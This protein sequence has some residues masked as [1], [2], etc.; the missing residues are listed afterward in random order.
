MS[1]RT[2]SAQSYASRDYDRLSAVGYADF[3]S[4]V[5]NLL[6]RLDAGD[7]KS[8]SGTG[9][10]WTNR[11]F[12]WTTYNA[13]LENVTYSSTTGG[14]SFSFNGTTSRATLTR[15][16]AGDFT[17][18]CWFRTATTGGSGTEWW[19]GRG[20]LDCETAG[21]ALDYGTAVNAGKVMFGV[22]LGTITSPATYNDNV[23][24]F[25]A[26]T[27]VQSSG[28][29]NLYVDGTSVATGTGSTS[30]LT[31]ATNMLIGQI[32]GQSS[33]YFPGDIAVALVY[34]TVLSA[35][36]IQQNFQAMRGRFG[37]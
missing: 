13:T 32:G 28:A 31:A 14:G 16:V 21:S 18:C 36:Q 22:G 6:V 1:V 11:G 33:G 19:Q 23:W 17:L 26:A 15:P 30:S 25:M 2:L 34:S 7:T 8:Y 29:L 20:L 12:G 24:H 4:P 10:T 5:S 9:T 35:S 3:D 37:V 27:R